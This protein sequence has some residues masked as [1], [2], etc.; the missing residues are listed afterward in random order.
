MD[1]VICANVVWPG[2]LLQG[3]TD[4]QHIRQ[5]KI[6]A[7]LRQCEESDVE[8]W[9]SALEKQYVQDLSINYGEAGYCK[10]T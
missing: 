5:A 6:V 4:D 7:S 2:L 3:T 10:N 9:P 8:D 1:L